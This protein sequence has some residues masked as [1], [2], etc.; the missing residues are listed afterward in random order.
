M[1]ALGASVTVLPGFTS[2]G[3]TPWKRV[4]HPL[5]HL[6]EMMRMTTKI[7]KIRILSELGISIITILIIIRIAIT[8]LLTAVACFTALWLMEELG[9]GLESREGGVWGLL[10]Q[11][12]MVNMMMRW[13]VKTPTPI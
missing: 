7:R 1:V 9:F 6:R 12:Y 3:W 5:P 11:R 2:S 4:L 13:L 8:M 10:L